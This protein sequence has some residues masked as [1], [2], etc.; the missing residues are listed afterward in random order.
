MVIRR[1]NMKVKSTNSHHTFLLLI[2]FI[3]LLAFT[4]GCAG[5]Q[6]TV[7]ATPQPTLPDFI[8]VVAQPGDTFE[9]LAAKYLQD[10]SLGWMIAGFNR[11][12]TIE[13]GQELIIPTKPYQVGGLTSDRY[14]TVPVLSY[15]DFSE[16]KFSK[17]I[18]TSAAFEAQMKLLKDKGYHVISMEKF[19]DFLDFK[20]Q[21]PEKSVVITIDDGW[22]S[23]YDIAFPIIKKYGYPVTL[24]VYTDLIG[25]TKKTLTWNLV[26]EM[27]DNGI[28]MQCHTKT[29]RDLTQLLKNES[30]NEYIEAIDQEIVEATRVLKEKLNIDTKF[31]AYPY[32][33][34]NHLVIALL[35]KHGYRGGFSVKRRG[36]PFF[37]NNYAVHRSMV[38]GD[39]GLEQFEKNLTVSS[40]KALK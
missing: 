40:G 17:M 32:G 7:E 14:Q 33:K 18:V 36:N 13:T 1:T 25:R 6:V 15:H 20:T 5:P 11:I 27:A 16:N 28:D 23:A 30:F 26:K 12:D 38:Y 31:I 3:L 22:L 29:H 39:L 21:I 4:G 24:F 19:F 2:G 34:T 8:P 9:A 35:Q 10:P 37:V